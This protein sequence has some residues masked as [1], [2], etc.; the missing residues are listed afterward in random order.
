MDNE[1]QSVIYEV[2]WLLDRGTDLGRQGREEGLVM[3]NESDNPYLSRR[4][5]K[6]SN[7]HGKCRY[8]KKLIQLGILVEVLSFNEFS[9]DAKPCAV[10][11]PNL[12]P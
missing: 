3:E 10:L 9:H 12:Q 8:I 4:E 5:Q 7:G 11:S 6:N 1:D 2:A